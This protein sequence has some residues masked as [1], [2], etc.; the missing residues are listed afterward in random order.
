MIKIN[1]INIV[2]RLKTF[3]QM[4]A[5]GNLCQTSDIVSNGKTMIKKCQNTIDNK[6]L[7]TFRKQVAEIA[8]VTPALVYFDYSEI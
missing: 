8:N 2:C 3:E 5:L 6:E 1:A 4:N 7:S